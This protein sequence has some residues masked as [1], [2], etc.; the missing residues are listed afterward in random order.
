MLGHLSGQRMLDQQ[1]GELCEPAILA[2][3]TCRRVVVGQ[4]AVSPL[5]QLGIRHRS[6]GALG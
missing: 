1:I 4:Q 6:L 5:E 3:E 2:N